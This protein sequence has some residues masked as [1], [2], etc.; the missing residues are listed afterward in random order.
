[1][2]DDL[3]IKYE[4]YKENID[5][6][7]TTYSIRKVSHDE[8]VNNVDTFYAVNPNLKP[9][10][11]AMKMYGVKSKPTVTFFMTYDIFD[12][13][14][15]GSYFIAYNQQVPNTIELYIYSKSLGQKTLHYMSLSKSIP[16]GFIRNHIPVIYVFKEKP[17]YFTCNNVRCIPWF[18]D[19][20]KAYNYT[21]LEDSKLP[22]LDCLNQCLSLAK[23]QGSRPFSIY[24]SLAHDSKTQSDLE[25]N[26]NTYVKKD[27][28]KVNNRHIIYFIVIL[29]L[30]TMFFVLFILKIVKMKI[31]K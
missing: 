15:K 18:P 5:T 17:Q 24:R 11:P 7:E 6:F 30:C 20:D 8:Q 3:F 19:I 29:L 1:M 12:I 27:N 9:L 26:D 10:P 16:N 28:N 14:T 13:E 25:L 4:L 23:K 31:V 2:N 21:Q 22:F